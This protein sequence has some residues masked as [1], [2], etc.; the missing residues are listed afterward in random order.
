MEVK[1]LQEKLQ[2][3]K[4]GQFLTITYRK[5]IGKFSKQTTTTIRL[6][7]YASV[8]GKTP[9]N[10]QSKTSNDIH[11]GNNLIYN[12]N[13]GKT[14]LQVFLTKCKNHKPHSIY[15]EETDNGEKEQISAEEFYENTKERKS[16]PTLM[17]CI[18]TE[19]IVKVK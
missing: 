5:V 9:S 10:S 14:R 8:S 19:N 3:K 4:R 16:E 7:D 6:I 18:L 1:E 13:T 11:L 17:F 2:A 15:W 12:Q